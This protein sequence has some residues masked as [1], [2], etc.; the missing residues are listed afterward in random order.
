MPAKLNIPDQERIKS[1]LMSYYI[2]GFAGFAIN[3]SYDLFRQL[4]SFSILLSLALLLLYHKNWSR[5]FII[6]G[7][8]II[9]GGWLV[10]LIGT[11]TG[12]PFGEYEYLGLLWPLIAGVP[13]ILGLNWLFLVYCSFIITSF[14]P[15]AKTFRSITG[16]LLMTGYD[17]LLEPFARHTGMWMWQEDKV[18]LSN[19]IAWFVISFIFLRLLY[20]NPPE[21]DNRL[22]IFLFVYQ[23]GLF[24]ALLLT[25][26]LMN[27]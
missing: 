25:W 11:K 9:S 19:Y 22:G 15:A 4:I 7:L 12:F 5:T 3:I 13:L 20:I 16:A 2:I 23:S 6:T 18:P 27:L 10:E 21:K 1:F 14:I 24:A 26:K 17:L 8:I